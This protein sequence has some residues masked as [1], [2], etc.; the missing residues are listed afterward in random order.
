MIDRP[1][2]LRINEDMRSL[3][4]ETRLSTKELIYP[5]FIKEG[6]GIKEEINA[7]PGQYRY[8]VDM[9]GAEMK[10]I[11]DSGVNHVI[12]FGI[13]HDG[14]CDAVG[15]AAHDSNGIVQ[16]AIK[17]I[18]DKS[19][20]FV[21][22]DVCLCEYTDHGHCGLLDPNGYVNNDKTL[23]V[24]AKAALSHVEAGA[25]M[26]AP[27]DMMDGRV[28]AIREILDEN[29][30]VNTPIMAYSAKYASAFYGPFRDAANS[31]PGK[32]NRKSYQMDFHNVREAEH[33]AQLDLQEGADIIMVKPALAYLDVIAKIRPQIKKPMAAYCVS[34][35]YTMLK[36]AVDKGLMSEEVIYE[37]HIAI[38][39]AGAD[40]ILTYFAK[41]IG[42]FL[43]EV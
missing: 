6:K 25:D 5:I 35:E 12:L 30:F 10:A 9:L 4:R 40:V 37:S 42:K 22:T 31:A 3:V 21:T 17:E 29:N 11:K 18:K 7:M 24:L 8:S 43:Q 34:G 15:S 14:D 32:G 2:R 26:V 36:L 41:D 19:D 27:S 1:R 38:K 39:R 28:G 13:P 20:I 33:E 16:R 23:D